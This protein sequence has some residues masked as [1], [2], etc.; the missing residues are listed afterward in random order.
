MR[1]R[2]RAADIAAGIQMATELCAQIQ[3]S[4]SARALTKTAKINYKAIVY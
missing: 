3:N 4:M 2:G 1:G